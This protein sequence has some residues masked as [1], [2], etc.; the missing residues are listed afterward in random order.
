[1]K[2]PAL[3]QPNMPGVVRKVVPLKKPL[4]KLNT[5]FGVVSSFISVLT[6]VLVL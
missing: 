3:R 2:E 1:M 5:P 6:A 4:T